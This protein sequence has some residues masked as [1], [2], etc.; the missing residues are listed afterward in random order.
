MKNISLLKAKTLSYTDGGGLYKIDGKIMKVHCDEYHM[1]SFKCLCIVEED[2]YEPFGK[3][4]EKEMM[5]WSKG[6]LIWF[7]RDV[8]KRTEKTD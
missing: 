6:Q 1:H 7:I 2:E 3:E 4:W 8:L 5:K